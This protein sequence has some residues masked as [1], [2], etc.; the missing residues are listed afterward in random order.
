MSSK[1][2]VKQALGRNP[3][4]KNCLTFVGD[5]HLAY[6]CGFQVVIINIETKEQAFIQGTFTYQHQSLAI[7]AIAA[8]IPKK[9]IAVAEKV[10]PHGIITFYDSL[11]L[12]K[13]RVLSTPELA[14]T[15]IRCMTFSDDGKY[16]LT[17]GAGP[18][19]MLVLWGVEKGAKV[20]DRVKMSLSDDNPI[21][22]VSFCPWDPTVIL[23]LGK[24]ILRLFHFVEGQLRPMTI[25][26]R[27]DQA[28]FISYCWLTE[29]QLVVGTE[30]GEILIIENFEVRGHI[31][32]AKEDQD[33]VYP[34]L[35]MCPT[36]RGFIIGSLYGELK[37]F[38]KKDD[39]KEKYQLEDTY[40]VPGEF[41][42]VQEFALGAEDVLVC[43]MS[44][45][46]I[47]SCAVSSL[48]NLKN[49]PPTNTAN[50]ASNSSANNNGE[51]ARNLI[52]TEEK[53]TLTPPP[54]HS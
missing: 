14:S 13:K 2:V 38:E 6:A 19:W 5:H 54:R 3:T 32:T 51:T 53:S 16:L 18:E 49:N 25:T 52:K 7:T 35:S 39:I 29:E 43:G 9:V 20:L 40:Y 21:N 23:V 26:L 45:H 27:R 37:V 33:E 15:E 42:H 30:T 1:L 8:N 11:T 36:A 4:V 10:E 22:R 46:Q 28:N 34:V 50:T 47:L 41:G 31:N 44:R 12:R 17:Q 48:H 24:S